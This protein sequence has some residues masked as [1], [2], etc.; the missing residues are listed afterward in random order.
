MKRERRALLRRAA[1]VECASII[2]AA[3]GTDLGIYSDMKLTKDEADIVENTMRQ[4]SD[5]LYL[6][7]A[8]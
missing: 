7:G 4:I 5:R 1:I 2:E 3:L 8:S 6:Q